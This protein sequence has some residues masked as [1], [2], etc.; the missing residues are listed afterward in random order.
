MIDR[1]FLHLRQHL[2]SRMVNIY[3]VVG[4]GRK[5][6]NHIDCP[7]RRHP[8]TWSRDTWCRRKGFSMEKKPF[9]ASIQLI[10]MQLVSKKEI[11][12]I[13]ISC[14]MLISLSWL[15]QLACLI[16]R[17]VCSPYITTRTLTANSNVSWILNSRQNDSRIVCWEIHAYKHKS[18]DITLIRNVSAIHLLSSHTNRI[19]PNNLS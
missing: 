8:F 5:I 6:S 16:R 11:R 18:R 9:D 13:I 3:R 17:C 2:S 14:G 19:A 4:C 7:D 12:N 1:H 10:W 15:V